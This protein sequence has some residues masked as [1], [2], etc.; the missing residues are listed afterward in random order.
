LQY[1]YILHLNIFQAIIISEE[2]GSSFIDRLRCGIDIKENILSNKLVKINTHTNIRLIFCVVECPSEVVVQ[3]DV[4][5]RQQSDAS[6]VFGERRSRRIIQSAS[7]LQG[8]RH[9][10]KNYI[11]L[12]NTLLI[13]E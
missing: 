7:Y 9:V 11:E 4:A 5:G 8:R 6:R 3:K 10:A 13:N 12:T 2:R 1:W